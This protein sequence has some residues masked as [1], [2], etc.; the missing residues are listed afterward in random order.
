MDLHQGTSEWAVI[1][2]PERA[3]QRQS[4]QQPAYGSGPNRAAAITVFKYY[5][6][7]IHITSKSKIYICAQLI[8]QSNARNVIYTV[9]CGVSIHYLVMG[10]IYTRVFDAEK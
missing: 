3:T 5:K 7:D 1:G 2:V 6:H 8:S 10:G 4:I 9:G